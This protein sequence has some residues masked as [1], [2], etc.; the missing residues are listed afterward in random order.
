MNISL[1][2][3]ENDSPKDLIERM[4]KY[5]IIKSNDSTLAFWAALLQKRDLEVKSENLKM[6]YDVLKE[7]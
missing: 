6:I 4:S 5:K 3:T 2:N 1:I 7:I